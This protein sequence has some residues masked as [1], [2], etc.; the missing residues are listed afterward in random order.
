MKLHGLE[1]T[2]A[3]IQAAIH[4]Y[5]ETIRKTKHHRLH[6]VL[7]LVEGSGNHI[8]DYGCGWGNNAVMLRDAGNYVQG[9]DLSR[10]EIDICRLV[11]GESDG[12]SFEHMAI[13]DLADGIFDYVISTEVLEHVHNPGTYLSEINR[14]LKSEGRLVITT[15]NIVNPPEVLSALSGRMESN[16]IRLSKEI[17]QHY[18]KVNHHIHAWNPVH[19]VRLVSSVG[20][21]VE[22]YIPEGRIP[23]R[24]PVLRQRVYL[25]FGNNRL[26]N[27]SYRMIF[28]LRK[29]RD[30]RIGIYD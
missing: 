12:L 26:L 1:S 13:T 28:R 24:L 10:N 25:N 16:L 22:R 15:P 6:K 14:V 5:V 18:R 17:L 3:D 9:I 19:F 4:E 8:L 2:D 21:E 29:V 23:F 11:W 30:V 20:F 7:E 27:F